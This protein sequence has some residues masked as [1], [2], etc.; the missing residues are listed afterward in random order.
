MVLMSGTGRAVVYLSFW[1]PLVVNTYFDLYF[2][3]TLWIE[4]KIL[5]YFVVYCVKVMNRI[6]GQKVTEGPL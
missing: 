2:L 4:K 6:G 1:H 3:L 5:R